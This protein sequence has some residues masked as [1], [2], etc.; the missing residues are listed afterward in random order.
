MQPKLRAKYD[1]PLNTELQHI[2][3]KVD[4]VKEGK[5][6]RPGPPGPE[7][8]PDTAIPFE[9]IHDIFST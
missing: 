3:K 1:E 8:S 2:L 7:P 9:Y 5:E 4:A 6:G